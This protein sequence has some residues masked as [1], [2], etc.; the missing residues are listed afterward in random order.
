MNVFPRADKSC[1]EIG[2]TLEFKFTKRIADSVNALDGDGCPVA[3]EDAENIMLA[4]ERYAETVF[5]RRLNRIASMCGLPDPAEACR[6]ILA[7]VREAMSDGL[8]PGQ[9]CQICGKTLA[10][11]PAS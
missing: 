4:A 7:E 6:A 5:A 11:A 8:D 2:W 10:D 9:Y 1:A 3:M